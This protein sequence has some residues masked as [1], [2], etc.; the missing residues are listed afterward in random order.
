VSV[1]ALVLA[2]LAAD[3]QAAPIA[4]PIP[5]GA[6]PANPAA[7]APAAKAKPAKAAAK[8][9]P[10]AAKPTPPRTGPASALVRSE[11]FKRGDKPQTFRVDYTAS[12]T[13]TLTEHKACFFKRCHMVCSMT[14]THKTLASQLWWISSGAAPIL[15]ESSPAER[16]YAGGVV[17]LGRPCASINDRDAAKAAADRLRP[18]QFA[19]ELIHD[20]PLL[21][22]AADDY[23]ALR[24]ASYP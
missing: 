11:I 19:E 17:D 8:A 7:P 16:E 18:S 15:A 6:A 13:W 4:T 5:A 23:L 22:K 21:F 10:A 3:P 14:V 20:R 2:L 9:V 12:L 24:A 1:I